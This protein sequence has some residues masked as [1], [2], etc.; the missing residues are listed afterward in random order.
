[1]TNSRQAPCSA[2]VLVK[3]PP[4]IQPPCSASPQDKLPGDMEGLAESFER[5]QHSLQQAQ[6]YVDAVVVS[7]EEGR[8]GLVRL[9]G[10]PNAPPLAYCEALMLQQP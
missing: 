6:A 3:P 1:M 8:P 10:A 7:G 2:L 5:L 4:N 9:V